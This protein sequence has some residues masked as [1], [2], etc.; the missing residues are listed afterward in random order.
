MDFFK[1]EA[2]KSRE[3]LPNF[4]AVFEER[5]SNVI[6]LE[7]V[8]ADNLSSWYQE[9]GLADLVREVPVVLFNPKDP[10]TSEEAVTDMWMEDKKDLEMKEDVHDQ[11]RKKLRD[12]LGAEVFKFAPSGY[13]LESKDGSRYL[14]T[15]AQDAIPR[16]KKFDQKRY[17]Q[18]LD[19]LNRYKVSRVINRRTKNIFE[20]V[21]DETDLEKRRIDIIRDED[22]LEKRRRE[23]DL[24]NLAKK[25]KMTESQYLRLHTLAK[26]LFENGNRVS[27][28]EVAKSIVHDEEGAVIPEIK[29]FSK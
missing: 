28:E 14:V 8:D 5:F 13:L 3:D 27:L 10:F 9:S 25:Y 4:E 6:A 29:N 15:S 17:S 22:I 16:E 2:P 19:L 20:T 7:G 26:L 12:I 24:I 1:V 18:I 21:V 11:I 23:L